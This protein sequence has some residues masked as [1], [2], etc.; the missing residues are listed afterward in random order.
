MILIVLD[1]WISQKIIILRRKKKEIKFKL[2]T[3][4]SNQP[5]SFMNELVWFEF[6]KKIKQLWKPIHSNPKP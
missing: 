2:I 1:I 3:V 4:G 5:N 6:K